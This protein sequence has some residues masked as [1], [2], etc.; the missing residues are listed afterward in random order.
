MRI[1]LVT[2]ASRGIGE[3]IARIL[4]EQGN[5]VLTPSREEMDLNIAASITTYIDHLLSTDTHIDIL[6]NNAGINK[7]A[8]V[9]N[10]SA[11]DLQETM[12]VNTFAAI[13]LI[14]S[15]APGMQKN[16]FGRIV[17]ISSIWSMV[18]KIGRTNYSMS[19]SA[20]NALTRS[21]AVELAPDN[22]MINSVAPGFVLTD[23]TRKNN[24]AAELEKIK[25]N[26]PI[27]RFA[28]PDE[29]AQVVAFLCSEN[30]SYLTGQ[31]LVVDG[32]YTCL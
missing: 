13:Q 8:N 23:L 6:V 28:A 26:I 21:L 14:Q 18:S 5:Q 22:V 11:R 24:T 30:N 3:A 25:Q 2:G 1:A 10:I 12:Q 16:H 7:I 29:I 31:T 4:S 15:L 17:N 9:G 19:K 27:K 32:G 20:L